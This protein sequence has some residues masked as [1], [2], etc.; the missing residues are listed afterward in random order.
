MPVIRVEMFK[1]RTVDQKRQL[2]KELTDAFI[3]TCG[4]TPESVQ[5]VIADVAKEDWGGAGI[6]MSDKYP[7]KK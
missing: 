7:D 5:I 3:R 6:L 1:G 4:G 2:V